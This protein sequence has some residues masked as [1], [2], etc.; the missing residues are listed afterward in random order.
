MSNIA[1]KNTNVFRI[2]K[3]IHQN[4]WV[5]LSRDYKKVIDFSKNLTALNKRIGN[6]DV[7]FIR[8]LPKDLIFAPYVAKI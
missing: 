2:L 1:T 7:V 5:A 8:V 6:K 4:K 3:N